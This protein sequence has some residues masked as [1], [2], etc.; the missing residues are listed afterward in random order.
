[1]SEVTWYWG[2]HCHLRWS[3][4]KVQDIPPL[5]GGISISN[6]WSPRSRLSSLVTALTKTE[7]RRWLLGLGQRGFETSTWSFSEYTCWTKLVTREA[8]WL[9][10][11]QQAL[12]MPK[13]IMWGKRERPD[14]PSDRSR[15]KV[16]LASATIWPQL[17]EGLKKELPGWAHQHEELHVVI[18][19][20]CTKSLGFRVAYYTAIDNWNSVQCLLNT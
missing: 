1:M 17:Y 13:L 2:D 6:S 19:N 16:A 14:E 18:K 9:P 8:G 3:S 7:E 11:D 5:W 15:V 10:K 12:R 4:L 20:Y